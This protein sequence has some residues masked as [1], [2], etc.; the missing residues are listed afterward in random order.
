MSNEAYLQGA[1]EALSRMDLDETIKVASFNELEKIAI[2]GLGNARQATGEFLGNLRAGAKKR[3]T[4]EGQL[5]GLMAD[6]RAV[7]TPTAD[8]LAKIR[9]I[10]GGAD[11]VLKPI[12]LPSGAIRTVGAQAREEAELAARI[13]RNRQIAKDALIGSGTVAGV[14][15]TAMLADSLLG[16]DDGELDPEAQAQVLEAAIKENPGMLSSLGIDP[17]FGFGAYSS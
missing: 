15:G 17:G 2:R 10:T 7:T 11:E 8:E 13:L 4:T 14:G 9:A 16:G 12:T 1:A 5:G 6:T 3:Y